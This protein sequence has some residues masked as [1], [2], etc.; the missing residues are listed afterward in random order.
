MKIILSTLVLLDLLFCQAQPK[1]QVQ[2]EAELALFSFA[3]ATPTPPPRRYIF[4]QFLVNVGPSGCVR[5]H[6]TKCP[7][8]TAFFSLLSPDVTFL[9]EGVIVGF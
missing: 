7:L 3:P 5:C 9:P 6:G 4:Q 8:I 1:F 2:L